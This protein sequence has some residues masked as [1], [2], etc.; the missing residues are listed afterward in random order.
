MVHELIIAAENGAVFSFAAS[1]RHLGLLGFL[2]PVDSW[3]PE[4]SELLAP[5]LA[6][7]LRSL[8]PR[9]RQLI[10]YDLPKWVTGWR[11]RKSPFFSTEGGIKRAG[12]YHPHLRSEIEML[13]CC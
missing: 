4:K 13:N 6:G 8:L 7:T 3:T 5:R 12:P 2:L 1:R 10:C 9:R 11:R